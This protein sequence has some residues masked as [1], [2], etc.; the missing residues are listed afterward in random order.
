MAAPFLDIERL[1]SGVDLINDYSE[2]LGEY[3]ANIEFKEWTYVADNGD[4]HTRFN[5]SGSIANLHFDIDQESGVKFS[6]YKKFLGLENG[7]KGQ[8]YW[9]AVLM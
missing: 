6:Q 3:I 7:A 8:F 2:T 4:A 5:W 9:P 1:G